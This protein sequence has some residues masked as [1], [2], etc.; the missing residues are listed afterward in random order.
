MRFHTASVDREHSIS[1]AWIVLAC[2]SV[3]QR[4]A[5]QANTP[6]LRTAPTSLS[7]D[8][9]DDKVARSSVDLPRQ[10]ERDVIIR[11]PYVPVL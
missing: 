5:I 4:E 3:H 8:V 9:V 6:F 10:I 11:Q 1:S 2:V 7:R